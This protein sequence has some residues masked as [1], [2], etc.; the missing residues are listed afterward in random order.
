M[1]YESY[2]SQFLIGEEKR[3]KKILIAS[4]SQRFDFLNQSY[5]LLRQHYE[6][7]SDS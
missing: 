3:F 7:L 4:E 6:L 2:G 1:I 5:D